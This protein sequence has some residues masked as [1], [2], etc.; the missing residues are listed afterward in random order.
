MESPSTSMR[1]AMTA[2]RRACRLRAS[3]WRGFR[4]GRRSGAKAT[5]YSLMTKRFIGERCAS[6]VAPLDARGSAGLLGGVRTDR[7]ERR[8]FRARDLLGD[9]TIGGP[10]ALA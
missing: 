4:R 10:Q 8:G 6:R 1:V 2:R 7:T 9:P 3:V 5:L